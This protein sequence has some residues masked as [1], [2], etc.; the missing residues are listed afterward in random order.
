MN[1]IKMKRLEWKIRAE[2][3]EMFVSFMSSHK[4]ILGI[5]QKMYTALRDVPADELQKEI[6]EKLAEII[7]SESHADD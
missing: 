6:V 3:Y 2:I 4:D 7:H 5:L 1:Y